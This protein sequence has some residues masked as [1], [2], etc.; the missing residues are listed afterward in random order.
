MPTSLILTDIHGCYDEMVSLIDRSGADQ[1]YICGDLIDRG[2]DSKKVVDLV[3]ANRDYIH[4]ILGNHELM[5]IEAIGSYDPH[6]PSSNL[7]LQDSDWF[8]NGGRAVFDSYSSLDDLYTHIEFFKSLP[9]YRVLPYTHN[10]KQV[11]LSH[12]LITNHITD[13]IDIGPSYSDIGDACTPFV[14]DRSKAPNP[15]SKYYNV[16]GHTPTDYYAGLSKQPYITE[17]YAN[18]DTGCAYPSIPGRGVLTG[19]LLPSF[20]ITQSKA[21][22]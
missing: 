3:I 13:P 19:L 2:P 5:A 1:V 18:L 4:C 10:G 11:L 15:T 22:L 16:F 21:S 9:I 6:L 14:W 7:L 8:F 20:E 12:T 17:H